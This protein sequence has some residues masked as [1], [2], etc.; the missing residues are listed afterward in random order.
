V[1]LELTYCQRT[2]RSDEVVAFTDP[3]AAGLGDD[4]A[5]ERFGFGSYVGGRVVVDDE[6]FGSLCF[7]D[8]ERRDRPFDE[9]ERLFVELLADWLGRGIERRIAREE[10]EAAIERFER[11]LERID[12]AFFA[13]DSDWRFTYVNEK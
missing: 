12:D 1:P 5:Y 2:V 6:V 11:T 4:P 10:R 3:E 7:L 9:S 8:P 13:L